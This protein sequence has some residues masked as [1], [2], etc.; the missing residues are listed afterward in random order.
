MDKDDII[1]ALKDLQLRADATHAEEMGL[2]QEAAIILNRM[3]NEMIDEVEKAIRQYE[4]GRNK[5]A[6]K[7]GYAAALVGK[8]SAP[9][10][11]KALTN[12]GATPLPHEKPDH[13][14]L[15]GKG[16]VN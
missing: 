13:L 15:Y 10:P 16:T 2:V 3:N 5:L 9:T 8:A 11:P 1:Q 4:E 6:Q 7:I 14:N 12:N